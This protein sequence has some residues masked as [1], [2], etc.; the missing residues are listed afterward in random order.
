METSNK[1]LTAEHNRMAMNSS[2]GPS[3]SSNGAALRRPKCA[4]CRN[5]GVISWLKGHK[6]H[7]RFKDCLCVK[8]NLIA[9]RQRVMAAQVCFQSECQNGRTKNVIKMV[10]VLF[11]VALKR[12]QATEDAIA[13]G[14]RSVASGTRMPFLPPGPIFGGRDSPKKELMLDESMSNSGKI[15]LHSLSMTIQKL[16]SFGTKQVQR[17]KS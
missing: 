16:I 14:L 1:S 15:L 7:C 4:R 9:E 10:F 12:Q 5:H 13:L 2:H 6:R 17:T 8:C 11:Q 3:T